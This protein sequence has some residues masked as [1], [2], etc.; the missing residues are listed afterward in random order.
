MTGR[1]LGFVLT[2]CVLMAAGGA[3]TICCAQT[4]AQQVSSVPSAP[5][6]PWNSGGNATIGESSSIDSSSTSF[7]A[8]DA[9]T[10]YD[11]SLGFQFIR[12]LASD[13][14]AIWTSP[15]RLTWDDGTWLF[16]LAGTAAAFFAT[17]P[18]SARAFIAPPH[19]LNRYREFS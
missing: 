7:S 9:P 16:P 11:N 19:T 6:N 4:P 14:R 15:S 17:D 12:N 2:S 10:D 8:P 1:G 5:E 13:Q 18:A 3:G